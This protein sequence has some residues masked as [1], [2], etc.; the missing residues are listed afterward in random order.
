MGSVFQIESQT[1]EMIVPVRVFD[2]YTN[3]WIYFFSRF[4]NQVFAGFGH[5]FETV[6]GP[7]HI[8]FCGNTKI[9]FTAGKKEIIQNKIVKKTGGVF[10]Y[11]LYFFPML[12]IAVTKSLKKIRLVYGICDTSAHL[13]AVCP[14]IFNGPA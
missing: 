6:A 8:A 5:E 1:L 10:G 12:R 2:D 4:Y 13:Y 7:A 11:F 3:I 14:E 9:T